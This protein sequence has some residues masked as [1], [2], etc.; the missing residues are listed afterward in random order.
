MKNIIKTCNSII[1]FLKFKF[2]KKIYEDFKEFFGE[3]YFLEEF[4][5]FFRYMQVITYKYTF[6]LQLKN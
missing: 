2:N 5:F 4:F 1:N 6:L 3:K